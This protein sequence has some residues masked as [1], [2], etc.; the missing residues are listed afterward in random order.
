MKNLFQMW[1][2]AIGLLV[3]LSTT[4]LAQNNDRMQHSPDTSPIASET[5]ERV[6]MLSGCLD[7]GAGA[8]EYSLHGANLAS[9]ELKS[10][11]VNLDSHLYQTVTVIAVK[12]GD[13]SG[14]LSVIDLRIDT[15]S[16]NSW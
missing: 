2:L 10:Y 3:S 5:G 16:C 6:V 4:C 15:P 1:L 13:A 11:S 8:N 9:W 14:T 7:R 12:S